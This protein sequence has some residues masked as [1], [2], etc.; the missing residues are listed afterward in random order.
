MIH[1]YDRDP[2]ADRC[3]LTRICVHEARESRG[4]AWS[5]TD[6]L[7][8][9]FTNRYHSTGQ[10]GLSALSL[11]RNLIKGPRNRKLLLRWSDSRMRKTI[12]N[13][14]V[15]TIFSKQSFWF[16]SLRIINITFYSCHFFLKDF[17][18]VERKKIFT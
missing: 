14:N 9:W 6:W 11:S 15:Y 4:T 17:I 12:S 1:E 5:A 2:R 13:R 8:D 18:Y 3:G 10:S 7:T 16:D